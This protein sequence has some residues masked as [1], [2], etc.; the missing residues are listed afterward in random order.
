MLSNEIISV[1]WTQ[2]PNLI[3]VLTGWLAGPKSQKFAK[4][5]DGEI[6][7]MGLSSLANIFKIDKE[8]IK[9]ELVNVKVAN[10]LSDPYAKGAYSYWTLEA[11]LGMKELLKPVGG[12]LFFAGE[13]IYE[14]KETAT[15]EG[16]LA[17]GLDAAIKILK[18]V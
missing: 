1:W 17:S 4:S 10:W 2:Y 9:K 5:S 8:S 15:V 7:D 11:D 12:R 6:I 18:S 16:A 3:P 13:A 14:G